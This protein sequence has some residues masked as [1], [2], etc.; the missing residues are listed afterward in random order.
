MKIHYNLFAGRSLER[1][2][3][4]SD[5]IFAIATTLLV[6]NL[7]V[8]Q[9]AEAAAHLDSEQLLLGALLRHLPELVTYLMSF[10]TLGIFW[11]GQQTQMSH[12]TES[13]RNY[14][15]I[16]LGFLATVTL[17]P[18]STSLLATFIQLRVALIIYWLN[19]LLMGIAL[20]VGLIYGQRSGLLKE[21][22]RQETR[23][24]FKRIVIA[25]AL[26]AVGALLCIIHPYVS[27]GFIV[28]VQLNYV[29]APRIWKLD[30]I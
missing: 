1:L 11:I 21:Q 17:M 22:S 24:Q 23:H 15:W 12:F 9:A 26:Y 5:G 16:Q 8:P 29:I 20:L 10:M 3:A 18:F 13:N 19:I 30:R 4:L 14:S 6:L 7:H 2:S 25:Q 27:I 28:L